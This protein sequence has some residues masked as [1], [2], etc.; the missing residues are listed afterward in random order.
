MASAEGPRLNGGAARI[1]EEVYVS[2]IAYAAEVN[3]TVTDQE[4]RGHCEEGCIAPLRAV[5]G[6]ISPSPVP[7]SLVSRGGSSGAVIPG[8]RPLLMQA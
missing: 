8:S 7:S 6:N 2:V 1:G 5:P 3:G 4:G